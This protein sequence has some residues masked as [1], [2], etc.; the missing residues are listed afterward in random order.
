MEAWSPFAEGKQGI[1]KNSILESIGKCY[2][3]TA[4]QVI[5]RWHI[6]RDI[7]AIPKSVHRERIQENFHVWDF[8]LNQNDM[9]LI[10]DMEQGHSLMLDTLS[11]AE[12]ERLYSIQTAH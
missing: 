2:G 5:L 6:Q 3:K 4:A 10:S 1:F 9:A 8:E 11:T 12:V 7:I